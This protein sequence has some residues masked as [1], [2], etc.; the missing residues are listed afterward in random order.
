MNIQ[1]IWKDIPEYEGLY[2]VSNFGNVK[3]FLIGAGGSKF[4]DPEKILKP[5]GKRYLHVTLSKDKNKKI[6]TIHR[7]VLLNFRPE[8]YFEGAVINHIDGNKL[9][10]RLDNLEWCTHSQNMKHAVENNLTAKGEKI[11]KS[12]LNNKIVRIIR[13]SHKNKYFEQKELAKIFNVSKTAISRIIN[14]KLWKHVL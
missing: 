11:G 3:S 6:F 5:N 13:I 9:N 8:K 12:K 2:Q 4:N 7:L 1:E 10:N 14:Y